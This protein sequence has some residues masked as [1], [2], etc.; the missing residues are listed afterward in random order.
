MSKHGKLPIAFIREPQTINAEY[1]SFCGM[2]GDATF[3]VELNQSLIVKF[4][5]R[6]AELQDEYDAAMANLQKKE[7]EKQAEDQA[8]SE[9]PKG[10]DDAD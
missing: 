2:L 3:K 7:A 4:K 1:N 10:E 9:A 6:L 8:A 5:K